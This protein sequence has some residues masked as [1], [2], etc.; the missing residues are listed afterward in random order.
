MES[1]IDAFLF[2]DSFF[3]DA[4]PSTTI[5]CKKHVT[6][7][8]QARARHTRFAASRSWALGM[9]FLVDG[10]VM[11]PYSVNGAESYREPSSRMVPH[12]MSLTGPDEGRVRLPPLLLSIT[13][14]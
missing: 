3:T 11:A 4:L 12:T 2:V 6:C 8:S 7:A 5:S 10:L 14:S 9:T 1:H 13:Q